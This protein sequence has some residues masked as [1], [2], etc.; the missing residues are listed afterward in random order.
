MSDAARR[1]ARIRARLSTVG[2]G[3]GLL[4]FGVIRS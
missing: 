1:K 4:V 2:L 3:L